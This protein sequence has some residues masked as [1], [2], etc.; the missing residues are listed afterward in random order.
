[1]EHPD[2][3]DEALM[4][5]Y[6]ATGDRVAFETL[7]RR[8]ANRL[9]GFFRRSVGSDHAA[10][11]LVQQTFL[12]LHRARRDFD[13]ARSLRPW[14]MTI[15]VNVR[16][17]H[18]RTR[19]RRPEAPLEL[20]GARDPSVGPDVSTASDRLVRRALDALPDAQREVVV[21]HWYEGLSFR[22]I[23]D[24]VGASHSAVKVRAH[25]AYA[26][27]RTALTGGSA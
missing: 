1:M 27:L 23:A 18:F 10:Q 16:R 17:Q 25:R 22:E 12:H 6:A 5:A 2:E 19:G 11:D 20:D 26:K 21:L 15:A 3:P 8:H 14:M 13:P 7:Y 4:V 9:Y 24:V